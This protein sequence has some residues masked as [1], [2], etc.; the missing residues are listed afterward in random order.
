MVA[1]V[2]SDCTQIDITGTQVDTFAGDPENVTL[3]LK[4]ERNC[5]DTVTNY[6]VLDADVTDEVPFTLNFTPDMI[7]QTEEAFSEGVYS[8]R[9]E[10]TQGETV[11]EEKTCSIVGCEL[12]CAIFDYYVQY[13]ESTIMQAFDALMM[14]GTCDNCYCNDACTLYTHIL[15]L[16]SQTPV[17]NDCGCS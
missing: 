12:Q 14:A 11:T 7:G 4:V 5:D 3:I 10:M 6:T 13:P 15:N 1:V 16:L 17:E 2:N 8:L 9:L